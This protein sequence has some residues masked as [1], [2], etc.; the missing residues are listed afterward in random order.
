M[1][2]IPQFL[3]DLFSPIT[4]VKD[5][6]AGIFN[7]FW[8]WV[9]DQGAYAP[10]VEVRKAKKTTVIHSPRTSHV[11]TSSPVSIHSRARGFAPQQNK[12][13]VD[14]WTTSELRAECRE[15][16]VP[17]YGSDNKKKLIKKLMAKHDAIAEVERG[18]YS[19]V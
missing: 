5:W 4:I 9:T 8:S 3:L 1:Q 18:Q 7:S 17:Y 15:L 14:D 6:L 12:Y 11:P 19:F 13:E 16:S 2:I 10:T